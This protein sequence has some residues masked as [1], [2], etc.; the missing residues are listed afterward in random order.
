MK[1][2]SQP[3]GAHAALQG[4]R[5]LMAKDHCIVRDSAGMPA[6]LENEGFT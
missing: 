3:K 2:Y 5:F 6:V 1:P 4:F